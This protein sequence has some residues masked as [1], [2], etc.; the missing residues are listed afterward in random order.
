M[1]RLLPRPAAVACPATVQAATL[2]THTLL[3]GPDVLLSDLFNDAGPNADRRLGPAPPAGGSI[4]VEAAQLGAI[5]R[6]FGVDWQPASSGDRA[7]LER[8]GRTLP[9]DDVLAAVRSA[10]QAAGAS[11]RLRGGTA[12]RSRRRWCRW[13]PSRIWS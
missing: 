1:R 11:D 12:R 6:Q 3:R 9:R 7:V 10:L 4:V 13:M 5:A 2:R 8:P